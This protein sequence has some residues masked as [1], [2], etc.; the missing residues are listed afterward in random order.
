MT[1]VKVTISCKSE[2]YVF[3]LETK[4]YL[5]IF[6]KL[7]KNFFELNFIISLHY[8]LITL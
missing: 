2:Y 8:L 6:K 4:K 5:N 7:L 3:F 1:Q